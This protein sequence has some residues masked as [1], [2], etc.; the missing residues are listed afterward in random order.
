M[1]RRLIAVRAGRT[2]GATQSCRAT[3]PGPR[4]S[5]FRS[6]VALRRGRPGIR[7]RTCSAE[8]PPRGA[9]TRCTVS[10]APTAAN[11][12]HADRV[13]AAS[14]RRPNDQA[15]YIGF[16][17]NAKAPVR[18]SPSVRSTVT[19][20]RDA[21]ATAHAPRATAPATTGSPTAAPT[22]R[23]TGART[24][25]MKCRSPPAR[26]RSGATRGA[27][28]SST[29]APEA[30]PDLCRLVHSCSSPSPIYASRVIVTFTCSCDLNGP[31]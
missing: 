22:R 15:R 30:A 19:P 16:R 21:D 6:S 20:S 31:A 2:R 4:A 24:G 10:E 7:R 8:R 3:V 27:A 11:R 5:A 13:S 26:G 1:I 28:R 12:S 23:L 9:P 18:T 14:P 29:T 25:A 17:V